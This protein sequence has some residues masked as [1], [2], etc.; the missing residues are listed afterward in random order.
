MGDLLTLG[1]FPEPFFGG[2]E[3]E[4]RRWSRQY[5]DLLIRDEA[6]SLERVHDPGRL[7]LM[8]V[9]LPDL[10]G[11]PLSINNLV[12]AVAMKEARCRRPPRSSRSWPQRWCCARACRRASAQRWRS[13]PASWHDAPMQ[14]L[15]VRWAVS[16]AA[17]WLTSLV[18]RGIEI[19]GVASLVF[20]AL[21]IGV[22]N[23][24]IR[25]VL[26]LLTLPLTILTL[27]LFAVVINAAMLKLASEVVRGFEVHGFWSAVAGTLL[28]SLFTFVI[29]LLIGDSG[30][31]EVVHVHRIVRF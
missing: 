28:M 25:P 8:M 30:R 9:R 6:T 3:T 29:N 18:V 23:A 10:V 2:S 24:L 13:R 4:A 17:L 1:G 15:L 31:I 5:R 22:L 20:A 7:E 21:A 16:A 12:E 11:S 14:G 19:R 27:G 26:L